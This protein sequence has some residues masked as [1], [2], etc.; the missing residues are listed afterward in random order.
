MEKPQSWKRG[1]PNIITKKDYEPKT[2]GWTLLRYR[3]SRAR[4]EKIKKEIKGEMQVH[5]PLSNAEWLLKQVDDSKK[6]GERI[7]ESIEEYQA[8]MANPEHMVEDRQKKIDHLYD[9]LQ[10]RLTHFLKIYE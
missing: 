10:N 8:L 1:R 6:W 4:S 3:T 5:L 9:T 7:R 2:E